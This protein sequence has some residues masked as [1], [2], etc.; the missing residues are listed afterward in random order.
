MASVETVPWDEV[1]KEAK[2]GRGQV[3]GIG[4]KP[5]AE[6]AAQGL[7]ENVVMS[8]QLLRASIG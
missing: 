7:T 8:V 6:R 4:N 2:E 5:V 1:V 3:N